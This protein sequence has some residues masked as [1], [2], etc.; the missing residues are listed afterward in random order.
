MLSAG[1][2]ST[3]ATSYFAASP[4]LPQRQRLIVNITIDVGEYSGDFLFYDIAKATINHIASGM[5]VDLRAYNIAAVALGLG[6]TRTEAVVNSIP[7]NGAP[8]KEEYNTTALVECA[9]LAVVALATHRN[10]MDKSG[11]VTMAENLADEYG[12][13][14]VDGTQPKWYDQQAG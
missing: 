1:V 10:V 9:G 14:D 7:P 4:M 3:M 6:W 11:K 13:T 12:F 8:S 2:W 5:A